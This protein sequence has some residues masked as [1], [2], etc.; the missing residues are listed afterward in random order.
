MDA[1]FVHSTYGIKSNYKFS[2]QLPMVNDKIPMALANGRVVIRPDIRRLTKSWVEFDDGS[3][4][5]DTDAII[6]ATGYVIIEF[7]FFKEPA[8]NWRS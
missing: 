7:S 4:E 1:R 6:Y 8:Y 5:D 2:Q 3:V